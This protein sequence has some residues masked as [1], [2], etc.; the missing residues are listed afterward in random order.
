MILSNSSAQ[1]LLAGTEEDDLLRVQTRTVG[2][3][4]T[5][6]NDDMHRSESDGCRK[7]DE[8]QP[9][10][11]EESCETADSNRAQMTKSTSRR[12]TVS[13]NRRSQRTLLRWFSLTVAVENELFLGC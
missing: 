4:I 9:A 1:T 8:A 13:R 12:S 10:A 6:L 7:G 11:S 2:L 5:V 3:P